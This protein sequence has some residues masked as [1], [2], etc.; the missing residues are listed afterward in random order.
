MKLKNKIR[1]SL[2]IVLAGGLLLNGCTRTSIVSD[3][4]YPPVE[5]VLKN[6]SREQI[7]QLGIGV[8]S[9]MRNGLSA[10]Y[11]W[12]G[13]IG[14]EVVYYVN[15]ESRYHEELQGSKEIDPGGLMYGWYT[16]LNQT[17]RRAE[18][19]LQSAQNSAVL[20]DA[21]KKAVT[22]FAKTV[23][24][25]VMLNCANMAYSQG[26][27]TAFTDLREP[28]DLLKPNCFSNYDQALTYVKQLV[29]DG[30]AALTNGGNAFPFA[31]TEGWAGFETPA[32][33]QQFNRAVAARIAMYQKDWTGMNAALN[34]SFINEAGAMN[35]G[36][37][38]T[39]STLA[40]DAVNPFFQTE[41][42]RSTTTLVQVR[43]VA[44]AE[45]NDTRVFG[46]PRNQKGT[47]K[48]RQRTTAL[49]PAGYP[50]MGY[51]VQMYETQSSPVSIIRNEELLLMKAEVAM[52]TNLNEAVRIIDIVRNANGLPKY[53]GAVTANAVLDE[54]LNQRR[55]SLFMEGHRWFDMRRYN[56]LNTLPLDAAN[57]VMRSE[58]PRY[59]PEVDWDI[60]NPCQ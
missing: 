14:R 40:N 11:N 20:T 48:V 58:F 23:Q 57:H 27:R 7:S 19:L 22:G 5:S 28:G 30:N 50:A 42:N 31:V 18:I 43:F 56:R 39:Y 41:D 13:C 55:Y 38:F 52:Q 16:G 35:A 59:R 29:E 2:A 45:A 25:Y 46:V 51:E 12:S 54:L 6:A 49:A 24:A 3:P 44:E 4:N 10:V 1:S 26:I 33:F 37:R 34:A 36:P 9:V 47:A 53:T 15:T 21:E 60:A 8:Q 32:K 17:R